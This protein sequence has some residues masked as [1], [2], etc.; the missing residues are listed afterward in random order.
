[1]SAIDE[2][3][4][5]MP[6]SALSAIV[7]FATVA[8]DISLIETPRRPLPVTVLFS[9]IACELCRMIP[10]CVAPATTLPVITEAGRLMVFAS[11]IPIPYGPMPARTSFPLMSAAARARDRDGSRAVRRLHPTRAVRRADETEGFADQERS[12]VR[13]RGELDDRAV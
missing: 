4:T 5:Q 7:F 3:T 10:S 2:S 9:I 12:R 13:P 11:S 8:I 6:A 1:M